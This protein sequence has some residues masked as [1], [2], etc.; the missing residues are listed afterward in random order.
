M[1]RSRVQILILGVA[2]SGGGSMLQATEFAGGT[3]TQADPYQIATAEQ[4]LSIR[5]AS[6]LWDKH[7][8]L[9]C[10]RPDAAALR[11]GSAGVRRIGATSSRGASH[12]LKR[13]FRPRSRR[14]LQSAKLPLAGPL[15]GLRSN[16]AHRFKMD[17]VAL[18][19]GP[20]RAPA[21]WREW[22]R[23]LVLPGCG[24]QWRSGQ[25]SRHTLV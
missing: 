4:L 12:A 24:W 17:G 11:A 13:A 25:R 1:Q 10:D 7:F 18:R 19:W 9:A 8:A 16:G 23:G 2:L 15:W 5:S 20:Y 22:N 21:G 3:G 6:G 14:R